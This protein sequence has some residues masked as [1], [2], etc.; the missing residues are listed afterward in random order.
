MS[1]LMTL[2]GAA[3]KF[4]A[5]AIDVEMMERE[6]I[7][8]ACEMVAQAAKAALGTDGYGWPALSPNT[9]KTQPGMLLETGELRD[10]IQWV[11]HG[12]QGEVGSNLDKAVWMEYGT[13]TIP[14]RPF[15]RGAARDQERAIQLM[16]G[17]AVAAVLRGEG[18]ASSSMHDLLHVLH[19]IKHVAKEIGDAMETDR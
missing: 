16:A 2:V 8:A 10:S 4:T 6:V 3:A 1:G 18:L 9:K 11:A 12:K 15:L 7:R 5:L 19:I 13:R 14:P 17:K